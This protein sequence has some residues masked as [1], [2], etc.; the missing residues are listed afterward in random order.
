[1]RL[2]CKNGLFQ[3]ILSEKLSQYANFNN[4]STTVQMGV[5]HTLLNILS[6][7]LLFIVNDT[8]AYSEMPKE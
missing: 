7:S 5:Q 1:M 2:T 3:T 8:S 4:G 6:I